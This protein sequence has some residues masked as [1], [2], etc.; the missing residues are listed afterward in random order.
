MPA[1]NT[2]CTTASPSGNAV[3]TS[4]HT[5][6]HWAAKRGHSAVLRILLAHFKAHANTP[7]DWLD[8]L[9]A[10]DVMGQTALSLASGAGKTD[11]VKLMLQQGML[12]L[13]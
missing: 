13:L 4:G 1:Q 10:V 8:W 11:C 12:H 3:T 7:Q 5:L 2:G 6:V 9:N